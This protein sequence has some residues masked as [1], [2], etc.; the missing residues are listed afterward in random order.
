MATVTEIANYLIDSYEKITESS[1]NNDEITLQKLMYFSQKTA[2]AFT[3]DVIF[4]EDFEGWVH[5]PVLP[6]LRF[7]FQYYNPNE[8]SSDKL[9]ETEK[10]IVD[11]TIYK[12]GK[13]APWT[14]RNMSHEESAWQKSRN[15]LLSSEHGSEII[16]LNDIE[17]D[18]KEIRLYDHQ[19]D[20]FIDEFEDVEGEFISV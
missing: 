11:N 1:F 13:Y 6:S 3:G 20:M 7:Y 15:G 19:F 2:I 9:T 10:Y 12:Y 4:K 8:D 5:G 14:L 16:A 18:A 17:E